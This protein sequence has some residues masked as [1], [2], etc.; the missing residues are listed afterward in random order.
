MYHNLHATFNM[1]KRQR[2]GIILEQPGC[3]QVMCIYM[4]EKPSLQSVLNQQPLHEHALEVGR[5]HEVLPNNCR[6]ITQFIMLRKI[7]DKLML[8][9]FQIDFGFSA[10]I[11]FRTLRPT[12]LF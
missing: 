6:T 2:E 3:V 7:S 1:Q 9:Y 12:I 4:F 11:S 8:L 5:R 10:I